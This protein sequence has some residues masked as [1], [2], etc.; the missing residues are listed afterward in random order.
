M[1]GLEDDPHKSHFYWFQ[2]EL[3]KELLKQPL[4]HI[5]KEKYYHIIET[6]VLPDQISNLILVII[7]INSIVSHVNYDGYQAKL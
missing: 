5:Q 7:I 4:L 6:I 2:I 1:S 3:Q